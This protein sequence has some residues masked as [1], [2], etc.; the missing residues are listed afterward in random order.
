M[1]SYSNFSSYTYIRSEF[2]EINQTNP[3]ENLDTL[4]FTQL[5]QSAGLND[6]VHAIGDPADKEKRRSIK[7]DT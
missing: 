4:N 1:L 3:Y 2:D 6:D 7:Y 5:T